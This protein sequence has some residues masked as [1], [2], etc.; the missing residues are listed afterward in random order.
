MSGNT[1]R[2]D[3]GEEQP[4]EPA[5]PEPHSEEQMPWKMLF[6]VAASDAVIAVPR[7]SS[8]IVG[9]HDP[10]NRIQPDVDLAPYRGFQCGVSRHH[11]IITE[12]DGNW[13][14]RSLS[15]TNSTSVN[16]EPLASGVECPLRD[17]DELLLGALRLQVMLVGAPTGSGA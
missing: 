9:R 13:Y 7:R 4:T 3:S 12:R 5:V 15:N 10:T 2:L 8:I 16:G 11:A 1:H 14:I 6:R 17:K